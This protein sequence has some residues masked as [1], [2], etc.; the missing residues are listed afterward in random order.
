MRWP[1]DK[2][3]A[4]SRET[5]L[6]CVLLLDFTVDSDAGIGAEVVERGA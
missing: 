4:A 1:G 5:A 6:A 2:L 3:R